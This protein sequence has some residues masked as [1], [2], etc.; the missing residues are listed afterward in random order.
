MT[1]RRDLDV[2]VATDLDIDRIAEIRT[3]GWQAAYCGILPDEMLD[4]L[5][6][7]V[8]ADRWRGFFP[9]F[10]SNGSTM[11][12]AT[13]DDVV[14]GFA[15]VS[16][17]ADDA[18]VDDGVGVLRAIYVHPDRYSTGAGHALLS[19]VVDRLTGAGCA[20]A[21]LWTF[22]ANDRARRFYEAH[23]WSADGATERHFDAPS[24]R[25]RIELA[26]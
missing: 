5:D 17:R 12:V 26:L 7:T 14:V 21:V 8:E 11:F 25:Y 2:R 6:V 18:D 22:E 13:D 16:R 20:A 23:G 15:L 3:R 19:A 24:V 10:E 9:Q 4:A 1:A